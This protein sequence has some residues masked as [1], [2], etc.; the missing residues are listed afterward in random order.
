MSW[1]VEVL[2]F[3]SLRLITDPTLGRSARRHHALHFLTT[4]VV[5][6]RFFLLFAAFV[7]MASLGCN[8]AKKPPEESEKIIEV[9]IAKFSYQGKLYEKDE[10]SRIFK[11][12]EFPVMVSGMESP[13]KD[14]VYVFD[15]EAAFKT[16]TQTTPL[17]EKFAEMDKHIAEARKQAESQDSSQ[18]APGKISS[19]G[20]SAILYEHDKLVGIAFP[21]FPLPA[22]NVI[23]NLGNFSFDEKASSAK[24]YNKF[25]GTFTVCALYEHPTYRGVQLLLVSNLPNTIFIWLDLAVFPFP[26]GTWTDK[27]SSMIVL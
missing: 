25:F 27:A 22:T 16:W 2:F 11:D 19:V 21:Q 17:A 7:L 8:D 10:F 4:E 5:M 13:D 23:P 14:V 1:L 15:S 6:K 3:H 18:T 20:G 9:K 12:K 26:Q 24:V